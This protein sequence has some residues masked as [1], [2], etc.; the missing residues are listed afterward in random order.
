MKT[1]VKVALVTT[2][3]AVPAFFLGPIL[4]PPADVGVEPTAA[5]VSQLMFLAVGD[6]LLLGLGVSF[7]LFGFPVVRRVSPDSKLRAWVMYLSIGYLM[8][9][10]WPHLNMHAANGIDFG[11]LLF[12]DYTFHLPLEVA[13]VAL[14]LSFITL[15]RSRTSTTSEGPAAEESP[16]RSAAR[17]PFL[18][19][20]RSRP[21]AVHEAP[22]VGGASW[23]RTISAGRASVP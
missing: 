7:L 16:Q 19:S 5:Q 10:W 1:W 18:P 6:A 2:L 22:L 4:F 23:P 11:G 17:D 9:S 8:V 20:R 14:A 12:I 13:G 3:V 21:K 15:M